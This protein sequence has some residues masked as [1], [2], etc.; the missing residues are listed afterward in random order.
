MAQFSYQHFISTRAWRSFSQTTSLLWPVYHFQ[1]AQ[2]PQK[3][4][5]IPY[6]FINNE[7]ASWNEAQLSKHPTKLRYL[8]SC[9]HAFAIA[10]V[11]AQVS[12]TS[13]S[14]LTNLWKSCINYCAYFCSGLRSAIF[15]ETSVH[16]LKNLYSD[17]PPQIDFS[18][19]GHHG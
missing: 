1:I 8:G 13:S 3:E 5:C 19:I 18:A 9:E 4:T 15:L 16:W 2:S 10:K 12:R 6:T 17:E 11:L 7:I 14:S